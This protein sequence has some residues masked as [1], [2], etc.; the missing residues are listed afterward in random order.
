MENL[1][2]KCISL[3]FLIFICAL[4]V[5]LDDVRQLKLDHVIIHSYYSTMHLTTNFFGKFSKK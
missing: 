4:I 3:S 1:L 2:L 5:N